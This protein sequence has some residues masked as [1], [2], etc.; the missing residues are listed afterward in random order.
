MATN[1]ERCGP[2]APGID[3]NRPP[4]HSGYHS[5]YTDP[6]VIAALDSQWALFHPDEPLPHS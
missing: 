4:G 2:I 1:E 3:C 5:E 6:A